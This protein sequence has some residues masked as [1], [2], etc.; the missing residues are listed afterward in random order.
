MNLAEL[1]PLVIKVSIVLTVFALGLKSSPQDAAH[2]VKRP[3][4]L[5]RSML[6]M[7]VVMPIL[8]ILLIFVIR[9]HPAV[10]IALCALSVSPVPPV[11]P[12]KELKAGGDSSYA[13][14][15]LVAAALFAIVIVPLALEIMWRILAR[16][17]DIS[18]AVVATV[19]F[20]TVLAPLAAG[21]AVHSLAP[22]FSERISRPLS[23]A[24]IVLLLVSVLPVLFM[25]FPAIWSLIGNGA[26]VTLSVFVLI[27]LAAGHLLGGPDPNDRTVLALSTASRHPGVAIAIANATFPG[28]KLTVAAVL[29]Y[30]LLSAVVSIP[31]LNW[32][33]RR[34]AA[35]AGA[36]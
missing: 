25:S 32:T 28:E 14:G 20:Q 34:N 16:P 6:S 2:L 5:V 24:A 1:I 23:V 21:I 22:A 13:I 10:E 35:A 12:R 3:G 4:Q 29:L 26:I 8:A 33:R 15:L 18:P 36:V 11:L 19:V 27:G 31:Y 9:L 17:A 30:V 7:N